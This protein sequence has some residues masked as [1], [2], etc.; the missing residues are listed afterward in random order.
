MTARRRLG[1]SLG[2][3]THTKPWWI[4]AILGWT[5]ESGPCHG[6]KAS[7]PDWQGHLCAERPNVLGLTVV[8]RKTR[9][10]ALPQLPGAAET[11]QLKTKE[12]AAYK[13]RD[14]HCP[15]VLEGRSL[16]SRCL[17]A[18]APREVPGRTS[19]PLSA[20]AGT[21]NL[22][23]PQPAVAS[24]QPLL[25]SSLGLVSVSV[26][27]RPSPNKAASHWIRVLSNPV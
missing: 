22:G 1:A 13:T 3:Q 27:T 5:A 11:R 8:V 15:A 26:S 9:L 6:T 12:G 23:V 7:G 4:W 16:K 14:V 18:R 19:P 21:G 24:L 10:I 17:Q 25:L 2:A 20:A